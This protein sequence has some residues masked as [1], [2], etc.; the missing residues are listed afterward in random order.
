VKMSIFRRTFCLVNSHLAAHQD[1]VAARN[2]DFEYIYSQMVFG[3][4]VGAAAIATASA[5][6][7]Y[8]GSEYSYLS[9]WIP[10]CLN[11]NTQTGNLAPSCWCAVQCKQK[12][13]TC[14]A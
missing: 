13:G 14:H 9:R 1:K 12:V 8:G 5:A 7:A 10:S 2:A 3:S 4:R 6:K 11:G